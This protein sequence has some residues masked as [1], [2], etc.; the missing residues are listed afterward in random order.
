MAD[1]KKKDRVPL[2]LD[3]QALAQIDRI[4]TRLGKADPTAPRRVMGWLADLHA[5][6]EPAKS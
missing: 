4:L 5:K 2:S 1:E 6:Q 3:V